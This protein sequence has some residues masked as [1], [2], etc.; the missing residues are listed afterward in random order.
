MTSHLMDDTVI[1]IDEVMVA[2][3]PIESA[4]SQHSL[5]P[6][7]RTKGKTIQ[8]DLKSSIGQQEQRAPY[9]YS[10]ML[11]RPQTPKARNARRTCNIAQQQLS[12]VSSD[13]AT[14]NATLRNDVPAFEHD[15]DSMLQLPTTYARISQATSQL[16]TKEPK[17]STET[18]K[19]SI[20][21]VQIQV[22]SPYC[23]KMQ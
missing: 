16:R 8:E 15:N 21:D 23:Q 4:F 13:L 2:I 5:S 19:Y 9:P 6:K 18:K 7:S 1:S 12:P 14:E 11:N 22:A 3:V 10:P 20:V 17:C